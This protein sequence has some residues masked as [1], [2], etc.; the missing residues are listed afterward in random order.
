MAE[1][2]RA[3]R[4]G[5]L[6]HVDIQNPTVSHATLDTWLFSWLLR[7]QLV[8]HD[9]DLIADGDQSAQHTAA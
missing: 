5:D 2:K 1:M 8:D 6:G 7:P 9:V 3:G 4:A